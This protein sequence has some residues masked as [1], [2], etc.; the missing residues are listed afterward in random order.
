MKD[1]LAIF[2]LDGTLFDTGEVNYRSYYD[3]LIPFGV[4]LDRDYYIRSCN[5]KRYTEFLPA[6]LESEEQ[7]EAVHEKKKQTYR[8]NLKYARVNEHLIS[9][10]RLMRNT[11]YLVIVTTASRK[12]ATEILRHFGYEELFDDMIAQEDIRKSKPDPDGFLQAMD[13]FG[14]SAENTV[15]FE[16]SDVGLLAARASGA[17]VFKVERF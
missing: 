16:D 6:L 12:N 17:A 4:T 1:K 5:G 8:Q 13:R 9:F 10:V 15:I 7:I 2:D 11:Y 3:A 14:I